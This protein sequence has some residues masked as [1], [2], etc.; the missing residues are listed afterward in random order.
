MSDLEV[1]EKNENQLTKK[2]IT[3]LDYNGE[4]YIL[5]VYLSNIN[6]DKIIFKLK[7]PS[8]EIYYYYDEFDLIDL[9]QKS[10]E[11]NRYQKI[12]DAFSYLKILLVNKKIEIEINKLNVIIFIKEKYNISFSLRKK[13]IT[14]KKLNYIITKHI[15]DKEKQID[16]LNQ[17]IEELIKDNYANQKILK[18][19]NNN[20]IT[21]NNDKNYLVIQTGI[22]LIV[23]CIFS[24]LYYFNNKE[25]KK[26][27]NK[28]DQKNKFQ[29]NLYFPLITNFPEIYD[30]MG[31]T[32]KSNKKVKYEN[33]NNEEKYST[34][35]T[36][37][38][39]EDDSGSEKPAIIHNRNKIFNFNLIKTATEYN[40]ILSTIKKKF[41]DSKNMC[42][43]EL[44]YDSDTDGKSFK[45]F[46]YNARDIG[47]NILFIETKEEMRFAIFSKFVWNKN[48]IIFINSKKNGYDFPDWVNDENSILLSLNN[49]KVFDK[50]YLSKNDFLVKSTEYSS[51]FNYLVNKFF[52]PKDN[53][54]RFTYGT[55]I[56]F[57]TK[58]E[59][60]VY[61][62]FSKF[63]KKSVK[64]IDIIVDK[65][66]LYEVIPEIKKK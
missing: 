43:I 63:N 3:Y 50:E 1:F 55:T 9:K 61:M 53:I 13:I 56:E 2:L 48:K 36:V 16:Q 41:Y 59:I 29:S 4:K 6:D 7:K 14:Q 34:K 31:A 33:K 27:K 46:F 40:F 45:D 42:N 37:N 44:R 57:L 49:K 39:P 28:L 60:G 25:L 24:S 18:N 23:I 10:K 65:I 64:D 54:F 47:P 30:S 51:Y 19:I 17:K 8:L 5:S 66:Q 52:I 35:I 32:P 20:I 38:Y 15:K 11:F 12:E 26:I 62:K 58:T 21:K 22:I